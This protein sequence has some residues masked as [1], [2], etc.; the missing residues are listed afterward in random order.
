[1]RLVRSS[2]FGLAAAMLCSAAQVAS[3]AEQTYRIKPFDNAPGAQNGEIRRSI[4]PFGGWTLI[5]D[6]QVRQRTRVCNVSQVVVDSSGEMAF[7][8]TLAGTR[9][10]EAVMIVRM[11]RANETR[12]WVGL[13]LE[14]VAKAVDVPLT[15]CDERVC[16]GFLGVNR[17]IT[18]A[19]R[20]GDPAEVIF[21]QNGRF[22]T[23]PT[24]TAGLSAALRSVR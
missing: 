18:Q 7:S 22:R 9:S 20:R 16:L 6:E 11:P 24:S 5:C 3:G 8:W 19:L 12:Q 4:Q 10:G 23:I 15:S 13:K 1:M 2:A 17:E 21:T 14:G